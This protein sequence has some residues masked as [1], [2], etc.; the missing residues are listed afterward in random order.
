VDYARF[1]Q[2]GQTYLDVVRKIF[3]RSFE[4]ISPGADLKGYPA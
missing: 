1:E 3:L 4:N 2:L